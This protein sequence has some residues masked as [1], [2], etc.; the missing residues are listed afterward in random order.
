[1][2]IPPR[3]NLV[4]EANGDGL[5]SDPIDSYNG[6]TSYSGTDLLLGSYPAF[7]SIDTSVGPLMI[8][9]YNA[10]QGG[11]SATLTAAHAVPEPSALVL[12]ATGFLGFA[13]VFRRRLFAN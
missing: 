4:D 13:G 11:F 8:T 10:Y 2:S 7:E 5:L 12:L 3:V 6:M 1:M 9:S